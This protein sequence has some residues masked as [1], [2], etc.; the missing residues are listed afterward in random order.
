MREGLRL[1]PGT[2]HQGSL[3]G[4]QKRKAR[5]QVS[6]YTRWRNAPLLPTHSL[7]SR[8]EELPRTGHRV[9]GGTRRKMCGGHAD[10][11]GELSHQ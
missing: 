5:L 6:L 9:R 11:L 2:A 10:E 7:K 8:K 1:L 3:Q 4:S